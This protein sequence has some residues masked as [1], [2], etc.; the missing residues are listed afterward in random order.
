[1]ASFPKR[2]LILARWTQ[3]PTFGR[4]AASGGAS[5]GNVILEAGG[6]TVSTEAVA[7]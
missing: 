7:A 2:A 6:D 3:C 5:F 4:A 1:M